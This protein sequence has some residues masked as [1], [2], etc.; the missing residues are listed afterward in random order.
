MALPAS[1]S[2]RQLFALIAIIIAGL[3]GYALYEQHV[4]GLEPCPLCMTQRLFYALAGVAAL[5]AAIHHPGQTGR[6]I[7]AALVALSASGGAAVAGRQVW[8]Q[9]L[10]PE[11]VPACGPSLEYMLET[12]PFTD[13]LTRVVQGDGNCAL[14]DWSFLGLSMAEWSLAW[15]IAIAALACWLLGRR[16]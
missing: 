15:F 12:L 7:Y 14:V 11:L 16:R 10:P 4:N 9:H 6:R 8:L 2:S 3:Y 1:L 5:L 13:V